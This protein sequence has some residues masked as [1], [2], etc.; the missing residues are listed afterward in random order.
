M[1]FPNKRIE[2]RDADFRRGTLIKILEIKRLMLWGCLVSSWLLLACGSLPVSRLRAWAGTE[3]DPATKVAA[4]SQNSQLA[5]DAYA[6]IDALPGYRLE[7]HYVVSNSSGPPLTY[8]LR[9]E[10]DQQQNQHLIIE[11]GQETREFYRVAGQTYVFESD[12]NGWVEL[13]AVTPVEAETERGTLPADFSLLQNPAHLLARFGAVPSRG[14]AEAWQGRAATRYTLQPILAEVSRAFDQEIAGLPINLSGTLWVDAATQALLKSEMT[15]YNSETGRALQTYR[16]EISDIGTV[17]PIVVPTPVV[18]PAASI[19]A[20]AT[21][22]VWTVL[23]GQMNYRGTPVAFEV[24]PLEA[25]QIAGTSP[26][27]AEVNV[28]LRRLPDSILQETNLEPFLA[29]LRQ[30]L[31]LSLPNRNLVV[32]SSGFTLE[33]GNVAEKTLRVVYSFNANLEDFNSV[34]VILSGRGNPTI[35]PVPVE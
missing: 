7:S 4:I 19:A 14:T 33:Q 32:T 21:A 31:T 9:S 23:D 25:T 15:L 5:A 26:L 1:F 24:I 2:K 22:Q 11:T 3:N 27:R 35:A 10:Q 34:E 6:N 12:Y 18:D 20:T 28:L 8:T 16:L 30:Q 13:G 29:Q 17:E